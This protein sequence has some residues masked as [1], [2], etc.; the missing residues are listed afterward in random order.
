MYY[1]KCRPPRSTNFSSNP[2]AVKSTQTEH[3]S[4]LRK[5]FWKTF[6]DNIFPKKI[7]VLIRNK[8]YQNP[9]HSL[10]GFF[11]ILIRPIRSIR[12]QRATTS[13]VIWLPIDV[14]FLGFQ[15]DRSSFSLPHLSDFAEAT[16]LS[17]LF[18]VYLVKNHIVFSSHWSSF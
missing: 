14:A 17:D 7:G 15:N 16:E 3:L 18:F 5:H 4:F 1:T 9:P 2:S 11:K 6:L 13:T 8:I 12:F 10:I